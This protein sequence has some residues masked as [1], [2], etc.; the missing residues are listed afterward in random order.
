[1]AERST[2]LQSLKVLDL[3]RVRA[4]PTCCRVLADFGADVIKIEAPVGADPSAGVSGARHGYDMLNLHRNKRS[5]T[6]NLKAPEGRALF[7]RMVEGADV[8]VENFRPDVKDRLGI[9]YEDLARVNPRVILASISG[10]GQTGPYARRAGFDQIAQGMGGLM[11]VTGNPDE[12]PMRAGAAVADSSSGLYAAIGI[13]VALQERAASGRGQ[14]VQSSLLEAQI[15]LMD[16]QAARYL[17]E[18]E[19]PRSTGNDHPYVTPM[20]VVP[21]SDGYLNLG[22]GSDTQWQALCKLIGKPDWAQDARYA[23]NAARFEH[24]PELWGLLEPIFAENTTAHWVAALEEVG[25]PAGPIYMMDE[26]FD[27][28]QVQHLEMAAPVHHPARGQTRLVAQPVKLSRTPA[29][30]YVSAPDAGE[31]SDAILGDLG[32]SDDEIAALREK[33]VI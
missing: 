8:V 33:N 5:L 27:D 25:V 1:M 17:V 4:G 19:V 23:T 24:R 29:S 14:W 26:V 15:A 13:F 28:P 18:G 31:H 2:A 16:F 20:G 7:L 32:L 10:F 30:V 6:L 11:G 9:A 22:V 12:G 21:T 3:T